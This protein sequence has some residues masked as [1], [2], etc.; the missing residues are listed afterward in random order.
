MGTTS[1]TTSTATFNGTS[2]Y[3]ADLQQAITKAVTIASLPLNQLNA[4]VTALQNQGSELATLQGNFSSIQAAI[5]SL[6]QTTNGGNLAASGSNNAVATATLDSSS[7]ISGGT[8]VLNVTSPGAPTTTVSNSTLPT[9]S[10]PS[11]TSI[12]SACSLCSTE[13]TIPSPRRQIRSARWPRRLT[14]RAR[15]KRHAGEYRSAVGAR[16]L[17]Y[18]VPS[19]ALGSVSIQLS[20]G[21]DLLTTS[22]TGSLDVSFFNGQPST[23]RSTPTAIR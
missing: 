19:T 8:Y 17:S 10:D 23:P 9:V 11:S 21:S 22:T 18:W 15:C 12:S 20:D 13:Q 3:A 16:L 4:N 5:Q 1:S 14:S 2:T 7:A 6:D